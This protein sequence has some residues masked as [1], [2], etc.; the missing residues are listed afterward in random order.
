[1]V[2]RSPEQ[3]KCRHIFSKWVIRPVVGASKRFYWQRL[4]RE[5]GYME[6]TVRES[7]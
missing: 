2:H 3:I 5:C 7:K 4:C 6:T 1:M